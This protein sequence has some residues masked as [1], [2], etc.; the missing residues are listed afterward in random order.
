M[1]SAEPG[2]RLDGRYRLSEV[3]GQ[4]GMGVV[5]RARDE[6]LDRDVAVKEII[7]PASLT[8][9]ERQTACRRATR[10]A[11][12][13]A[14][15]NHHNVVRIYDIVEED[16]HPWIVME[17]LPYRSL[18]DIMR[19]EGPVTPAVAAT[20]GLGI[21]AALRAAHAEGIA[22]RDVKPANVLV[23]PENRVVLTDFGIAR[24][25]DT[26][27][28]TTA[29][30]LI[31]SPSYIA[32]ERARGGPS[33]A[34][35]DLWG[36]GASLYAA[37]EGHPPFER[38]TALA[39]LTAV[40]ADEPEPATHAGP[41]WPV[42]SGLLRKDPDERLGAE[43]TDQALR[44]IAAPA[45]APAVFAHTA[46]PTE[47]FPTKPPSA[48]PD[49]VPAEPAFSESAPTAA[50]AAE[51]VSVEP[52][53]KPALAEPEPAEP[54]AEPAPAESGVAK[55]LS[56]EPGVEPAPEAEAGPAEAE[57]AVAAAAP[58]E[59]ESA[60]PEAAPAQSASGDPARAAA[61]GPVAVGL[62]SLLSPEPGSTPKPRFTPTPRVSP[63]LRVSSGRTVSTRSP[64][65]RRPRAAVL[66]VA[67]LAVLAAAAIAVALVLTNSPQHQTASPPSGIRSSASASQHPSAGTT[68]SSQGSP[69]SSAT[70]SS[71]TGNARSGAIPAGFYRFTNSTGFS[72][73]VPNGWQI[74]H[75]GHYVYITDPDN[76]GIFLLIDQSDN[77]NPNPLADWEQQ[78]ANRESGYPDYHRIRLQSVN[79][80]QAEKA[81][82]WEFTYDR[83]GVMVH[84]LN[85]NIL[86]NADHAYALYWSTP[87]SDWNAYFRYFQ[88]FA[89]TFRP[90]PA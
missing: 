84:I 75:V 16:D 5:W 86:A 46:P 19:D 65:S 47:P 89:A 6:L 49:P 38:N 81:A 31:G 18:R 61:A 76:G 25:A 80:S 51:L 21:L 60:D 15:L 30:I 12:M 29:G 11:Q 52:E 20:V 34:S 24:A 85:R 1:D 71:G 78:E 53:A 37:V 43:E 10:E 66:G 44:R 42:I 82:D 17:L 63:K 77:P 56:A 45:A 8:E 33:G 4:G 90:A 62:D 73:G 13:A 23:S 28:L 58:V 35:G 27:T 50:A 22:H 32:P 7:W 67:A 36:L 59:S 74:S 41:L 55:P 9:H 40:V 57:T 69:S 14:R 87:E 72:I 48:A 88:A 64:G 83:N 79:Y 39:T 70:A 3:I 2:R 54:E 26:S 68:T